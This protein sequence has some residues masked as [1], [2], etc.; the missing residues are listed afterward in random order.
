MRTTLAQKEL[1]AHVQIVKKEA[2]ITETWLFKDA[3]ALKAITQGIEL[4]HH[5][6]IRSVSMAMHAW[7]IQRE[8]YNRTTLHNRI[9]MMRRLH[10]F[11]MESCSTMSKHLNAYVEL[12]VGLQSL[13]EP[14][15]ESQ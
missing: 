8:F 1:L 2:K 5:I 9:E 13:R 3:K 10:K 14:V 11:K 15:D 7:S 6:K 12:L 4:Q